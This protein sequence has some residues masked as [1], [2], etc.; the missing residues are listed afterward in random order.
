MTDTT[1]RV[2]RATVE[3]LDMLRALWDSMHLPTAAL[4]PRLTEFQVVVDADEKIVGGI[5]F[6]IASSQGHLHNEGFT[7]FGVADTARELLWKRIQTLST[8]HGILRLWMRDNALFWTRLGFHPA[9]EQELKRLPVAWNSEGPPWFTFQLK[10]EVAI[11]AVEQEMAMFMTAS[12]KQSE[13]TM[14]Q[15]RVLKGVALFVAILF[16][17]IAFG[18]AGYMLLKRPDLLHLR[19]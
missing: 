10:D 13:R 1:L 14:E 18:A 19:R 5:G 15:L 12:K 9:S 11:N 7:D 4:E 3:D 2:R 8:N 16:A 17:I 6:Q